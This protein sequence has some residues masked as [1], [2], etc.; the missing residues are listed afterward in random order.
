MDITFINVGYGESILITENDSEAQNG[1]FV[2]LIDGG[3]A[4]DSEYTGESGRIRACDYLKKHHI[5][6][7]DLLVFSHVHEDHVCGLVP[8]VSGIPVRKYWASIRLKDEVIGKQIEGLETL[9]ETNKKMLSS[10]NA[11]SSL[12][13]KI[14]AADIDYLDGFKEKYFNCGGFSIDILGPDPSYKKV[15]EDSLANVFAAGDAVAL[16][17]A[18]TET[19]EMMNNASLILRINCCGKSVLLGA[20]TN[21]E[22]FKSLV[23]DRPELMKAD[24]FKIGHHGQADAVNEELLRAADPSVVVCCASNDY[25]N[26]SSNEKTFETISRTLGRNVTYLFQDGLYAEQWN[27]DISPRNGVTVHI[28]ETGI[29]LITEMKDYIFQKEKKK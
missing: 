24:V 19:T 27:P 28:D 25:R 12:I 21:A 5:D 4:M 7:I 29:S 20:D 18:L 14:P 2:M 17:K 22:G 3:S 8:V 16:D 10:I 11:Y 15:V 23:K 1:T 6:H 13:E 9:S 26:D